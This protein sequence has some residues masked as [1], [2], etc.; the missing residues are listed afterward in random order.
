M[1]AKEKRFKKSEKNLKKGV[2]KGKQVCYYNQALRKSPSARGKT[3]SR[4]LE[5]DT[6]N[7]EANK[8]TV[9]SEMSFNLDRG[10]YLRG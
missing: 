9:N 7:K 8:T 1:Y 6:G 3:E 2:D 5:N 4:D 10:S